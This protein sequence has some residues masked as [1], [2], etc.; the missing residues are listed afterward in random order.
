M[1][2]GGQYRGLPQAVFLKPLVQSPF[3]EIGDYTYYAD[4]ED[5]TGFE[6][7]N[8][9]YHFGPERLVIGS[10]CALARGTTFIMGAANHRIG[11]SCYPFP[12]F[13]ADWAR[14][15]DL[16]AGRPLRG[17]TVVGSDVW[18]GHGAT[19]MAGARIG[20]GA[21]VAA[22]SVVSGEVPPYAVVAGNPARLVRTR[23]SEADVRRLLRI[24]W[25]DW[26]VDQVTQHLRL[27]MG[28]DID[29]L[30]QVA[31]RVWDA[32]GQPEKGASADDA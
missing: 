5:P 1:P 11:L 32:T 30:E 21:I 25:W 27:V 13:G 7:N 23:Y 10:Y 8:V 14:H 18:L 6:R 24:A 20:H 19:V 2:Q 3:T 17:D 22:E 31:A 12:M 15:M 4:P 9:L 16:Y 28:E 29:Q 26:P